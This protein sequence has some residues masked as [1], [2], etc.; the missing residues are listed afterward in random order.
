VHEHFPQAGEI[1]YRWS[2]QVMEPLDGLAFIGKNPGKQS[3]IHYNG[4]SGNGMTHGTI[5]ALLIT[6]LIQGKNNPWADI[7]N[8]SRLMWRTPIEFASD[9][10]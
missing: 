6:D 4:D 8:P 1:I 2:G 10:L 3:G 7:Y 9:G 5:G